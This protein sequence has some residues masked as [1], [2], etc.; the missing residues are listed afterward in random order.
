M[1]GE[2]HQVLA[3]MGTDRTCLKERR[4][5]LQQSALLAFAFTAPWFANTILLAHL[6]LLEEAQEKEA[7]V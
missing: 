7:D 5:K 3:A 4:T 1:A 2:V 6:F